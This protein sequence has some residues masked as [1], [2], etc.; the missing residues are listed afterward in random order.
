[1]PR[2]GA[3]GA[4]Q[5]GGRRHR[6]VACVLRHA[7]NHGRGACGQGSPRTGGHGG[8]G[9][10]RVC[11]T[12]AKRWRAGG[13]SPLPVPPP[14]PAV[15]KTRSAPAT[16]SC[17]VAG[18]GL[19][20]PATTPGGDGGCSPL[21]EANGPGGGR[22]TP[23]PP[24]RRAQGCRRCLQNPGG[25]GCLLLGAAAAAGRARRGEGR[26]EAAGDGFADLD[27]VAGSGLQQRLVRDTDGEGSEAVL[28]NEG[29]RA[30]LKGRG[31][32]LCLRVGVDCPELDALRPSRRGAGR[33]DSYSSEGTEQERRAR[34]CQAADCAG[35]R[36]AGARCC[37][38]AR[39]QASHNHAIH[40]VPTAAAASDY[41]RTAHRLR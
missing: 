13:C 18:C 30:A 40:C 23:R 14:M 6:Q 25:V 37:D 38:P 2:G 19:E 33:Q 8:R 15:M 20:G 29:R 16:A 36:R 35:G 26:A 27:A 31:G 41:L 24:P 10:Q 11:G 22:E 12:T 9:Y 5:R 39:L 7:G 4:A 17:R 28:N 21:P 34:R 32:G 3:A 1:M